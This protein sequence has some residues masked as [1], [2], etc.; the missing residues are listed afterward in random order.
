MRLRLS[1]LTE[2]LRSSLFFLPMSAV[3]LAVATALL[4]TWLDAEISDLAEG[5]PLVLVSTVDNARAVLSTL[6][7]A[8]ISFAGIAFSVALLVIQLTSSQYSPRVVH[9]L[10]R[11]PFN[12]RVVALVVGTFTFCVMVLRSVR[13]PLDSGGDPVVPNLSL[14][15]ALVLGIASILGTVAFIDHSAHSM[16]VS[17]ILTRATRDAIGQIRAGGTEDRTGT[18]WPRPSRSEPAHVVVQFSED[19][20]VQQIDLEA[21]EQLVPSNGSIECHTSPGRYAIRGTP[22]CSV[23]GDAERDDLERGIHEAVAL[24]ASRTMQQ[25][26]RYGLRQIV[27]VALRALSTG[28]NDPTTAQDALV[29]AG[30]VLAELL[31]QPARAAVRPTPRGGL[32]VLSEEPTPESL[33]GLAF[34]EIRRAAASQPRVC[35]DLLEVIALVCSAV[36]EDGTERG[37]DALESQAALV[38]QG[39]RRSAPMPQDLEAVRRV[40]ERHFPLPTGRRPGSDPNGPQDR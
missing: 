2:R 12:R 33:V 6:A 22:I 8:T 20:W 34:D 40:H 9:T 7:A 31:R 14:T 21:L 24:G 16:D 27:D 29:H 28:V 11:D 1:A 5:M 4:T 25:D 35:I 26:E 10:F 32:L 38:V 15:A 23:W 39:C 17:Q 3:A 13:G 37:L 18:G 30:A 19:G 36:R